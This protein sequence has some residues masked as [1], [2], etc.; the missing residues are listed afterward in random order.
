V[1][2]ADRTEVR[3][4]QFRFENYT[5]PLQRFNFLTYLKNSVFV[6]VTAT[7]ITLVVN[8]MAAFA[9]AKYRFRGRNAVFLVIL[10]TL[11]I[12]LSVVLV[13]VYLVIMQVGWVNNLWGVRSEE[14]R[15]GKACRSAWT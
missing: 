1:P 14:R 13:P 9:L 10:G 4:L 12:P 11:M 5:E 2:V 3:S 7:L 6:T 15:A 8:S